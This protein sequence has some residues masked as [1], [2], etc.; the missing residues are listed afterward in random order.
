MILHKARATIKRPGS[1][2]GK[3]YFNKHGVLTYGTP[4]QPRAKHRV[5]PHHQVHV[6]LNKQHKLEAKDTHAHAL[7]GLYKKQKVLDLATAHAVTKQYLAKIGKQQ[8]YDYDDQEATA[9]AHRFINH[10]HKHAAIQLTEHAAIQAPK[11]D[12]DLLLQTIKRCIKPPTDIPAYIANNETHLKW[13]LRDKARIRVKPDDAAQI[14]QSFL[15]LL[16]TAG[17]EKPPARKENWDFSPRTLYAKTSPLQVRR[18]GKHIAGSYDQQEDTILVTR[19]TFL[20]TMDGL[21][22]KLPDVVHMGPDYYVNNGIKVFVHEALHEV[23]SDIAKHSK[24]YALPAG[25]VFEEVSTEFLAR[26]VAHQF[27]TKEADERSWS[28]HGHVPGRA[29]RDTGPYQTIIDKYRHAVMQ[30]M[31]G[32]LDAADEVLLQACRNVKQDK[33]RMEDLPELA[34]LRTEVTTTYN[35]T[36][37][38]PDARW[39]LVNRLEQAGVLRKVDRIRHIGLDHCLRVFVRDMPL[40][41]AKKEELLATLKGMH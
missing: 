37:L 30:A 19:D 24:L 39:S 5:V 4:S 27:V 17:F 20:T 10:L 40:T 26:H 32:T 29:N 25:R 22:G 13:H 31:G 28:K 38:D 21:E 7:L 2:G 11:F 41:A 34:Q 9:E 33:T 3:Y 6:T 12:R 23:S 18:L 36:A 14:R 35:D 8:G 15:D 1:R 16:A